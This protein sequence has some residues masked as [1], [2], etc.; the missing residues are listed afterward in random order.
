MGTIAIDVTFHC[1]MHATTVYALERITAH[2][3]C[4]RNPPPRAWTPAWTPADGGGKQKRDPSLW[5]IEIAYIASKVCSSTPIS[6]QP[7][8]CCPPARA[9]AWGATWLLFAAFIARGNT[10]KQDLQSMFS[11]TRT[12]TTCFVCISLL[13]CSNA[14]YLI[15]KFNLIAT[16]VA[17][18]VYLCSEVSPGG[19]PRSTTTVGC[20]RTCSLT[21]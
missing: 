15:Y 19:I 9:V 10:K 3:S 18:P 13:L 17:P 14:S 1:W 2:V 11:S 21:L 12:S 5:K 20:T 16:I 6:V 8:F 7:F 4:T